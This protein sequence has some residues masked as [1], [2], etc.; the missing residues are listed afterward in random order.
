ML[1]CYTAPVAE[2]NRAKRSGS[3]SESSIV[4]LTSNVFNLVDL[5][6][7]DVFANSLLNSSF[8]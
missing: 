5:V 3:S 4:S 2:L 8:S 6:G 7:G 1:T